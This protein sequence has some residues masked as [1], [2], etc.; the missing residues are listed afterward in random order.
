MHIA[1]V[2]P[3][4]TRMHGASKVVLLFS[5]EL[6]KQNTKNTIVTPICTMELPHWFTA[7]VRT[8]F[9]GRPG[10]QE[11]H[12]IRKL[13]QIL[14]QIAW[15]IVL[16]LYVPK[17]TDA[18]V[19]HGEVSLF[20][21]P[22][23]RLRR[24]IKYRIYYC[25]QPPR[26][27]LDL[28]EYARMAYGRLYDLFRPLFVLYLV[29]HKRLARAA[30]AVLVWSDYTKEYARKVYGDHEFHNIPAGVDF[31]IYERENV[32]DETVES[33]KLRYNVKDTKVMLVNSSLTK[34]KNIPLFLKLILSLKDAGVRVKGVV[35]GEGP[36]EAALTALIAELGIQ[37]EVELAKFVSQEDLP[38]YYHVADVFLFLE[39]DGLW[40]MGTIEAGAARVPV[41]VARGGAMPTLVSDG[42]TGHIVA[43]LGKGQELFDKVY[44]ILTNSQMRD[45]MGEANYAHSRQFSS[46]ASAS[47]FLQVLRG[48]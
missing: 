11:L 6:Q 5:S 28:S 12:G 17:D 27:L 29:V 41:V 37:E 7:D 3:S 25:Y 22:L 24:R 35:I 47:A 31:S 18:I 39:P 14:V 48:M 1:H 2:F 8:M 21:L 33:L 9:K 26:E 16:P 20:A 38:A 10:N 4:L 42:V 43:D 15:M 46:E 44:A 30:D 45:V 40:T 19:F 32:S 34:K 13:W 36:E 23:S